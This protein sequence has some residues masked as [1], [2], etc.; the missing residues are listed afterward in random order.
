MTRVP[1]LLVA[2]VA[3]ALVACDAGEVDSA[4]PEGATLARVQAE[5]F[6]AS[7]AFS[8][9][10]GAASPAGGL[11]LRPENAHAALVNVPASTGDVLVVPGDPD[12][13]YLVAKVT[14]GAEIEGE[15]MPVGQDGLD[16]ERLELLRGWIAD[17]APE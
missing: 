17:G 3:L 5:V 10:H 8:T 1:L 13:S 16:D 12:A 15:P 14:P 9:C 2:P 11:D 4:E 6:D 7:C